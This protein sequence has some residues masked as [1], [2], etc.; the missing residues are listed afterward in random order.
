M[1]GQEDMEVVE[2]QEN[3]EVVEG[4]EDV[5]VIEGQEE[6]KVIEGQK[7]VKVNGAKQIEDLK[8]FKWEQKLNEMEHISYVSDSHDIFH[9][10]I[11]NLIIYNYQSTSFWSQI[12]E[13]G[14]YFKK[15]FF[16]VQAEALEER[17]FVIK[18]DLI[19]E[20]CDIDEMS[21]LDFT[22][23]ACDGLFEIQDFLHQLDIQTKV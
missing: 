11:F 9:V 2:G 1:E 10:S 12:C 7:E 18:K 23:K 4:Q 3:M 22:H 15:V 20:T 16:L 5:E 14:I 21:I 13:R 17:R 6:V 8:W 19:W